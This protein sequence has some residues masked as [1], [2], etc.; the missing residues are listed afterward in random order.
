MLSLSAGFAELNPLLD[1]MVTTLKDLALYTEY[2]SQYT[3]FKT[4]KMTLDG[5]SESELAAYQVEA[6]QW[7]LDAIIAETN[8]HGIT[9]DNYLTQLEA[10]HATGELTSDALSDWSQLGDALISVE[11]ALSYLLETTLNSATMF[12]DY[13]SSSTGFTAGRIA[14]DDDETAN[15]SYGI[16]SAEMMLAA[17]IAETELHGITMDNYEAEFKAAH[18]ANDLTTDQL[19]AWGEL[20]SALLAVETAT[21]SYNDLLMTD[22]LAAVKSI[23]DAWLGSLSYLTDIQKTEY[24]SGLLTLSTT[25]DDSINSVDAAKLAAETAMRTTSTK[26]EYIPVFNRYI[27]ELEA[28][29]EEATTTDIL[30]KLDELIKEVIISKDAT[31][32]AY[33]YNTLTAEEIADA[34]V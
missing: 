29:G 6:S 34:I 10:A 14:L 26:E 18:L 3:G 11:E 9:M 2:V 30:N 32:D 1:E 15:A 17:I 19:S 24:A 20:G 28:E 12:T 23:T 16:T 31:V 7:Y 5:A 22:G 33:V 25:D 21:K 4:S 27:S 8:L 13:I